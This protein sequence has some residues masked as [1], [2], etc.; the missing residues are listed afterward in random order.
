MAGERVRKYV[1]LLYILLNVLKRA[2][3]LAVAY[4]ANHTSLFSTEIKELLENDKITAS[5]QTNMSSKHY[6]KLYK[7][8]N[9][10][11]LLG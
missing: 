2:L 5:Y 3:L 9:S 6:I 7:K 4:N 11:N 1:C 10:E 8:V